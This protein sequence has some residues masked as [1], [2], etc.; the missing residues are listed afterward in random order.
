MLNPD[1]IQEFEINGYNLPKI[2]K[3]QCINQIKQLIQT[4][5]LDFDFIIANTK[6]T[7]NQMNILQQKSQISLILDPQNHYNISCPVFDFKK[8][9][10]ILPNKNRNKLNEIKSKVETLLNSSHIDPPQTIKK[11]WWTEDEDQQLQDLVSQYGAKNWKKIASFF[12]DRTDVQCLHRWQKV[13]NPDLVKGPW[14]QEEDELLVTLVVGYGPKN[15]SQIAKHL[16]GRI[17]K[18]CRERFHNHLD[19][20]IN[21]ERWTDEEDQTIIEA[22]KKLG[23]RWSLIA[24]LLKGR[25]D[26]SIK[27]HWNSTLKRRLKMQNRWEDLQVLQNQD[28]TQI[29]GIPRRH[30]Q[31]K[32]IYQKTPVKMIKPDPVS[33]QLNF[34]TPQQSPTKLEQFSKSLFIVFPN[35]NIKL[36][37]LSSVTLIKQ[38]GELVNFD[39]DFNKQY[40][41]E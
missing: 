30:M 41:Y 14:T 9:Q 2:D 21:K 40:S 4:H 10:E 16:P 36:M 20:K 27:N 19:P 23:N 18:Q 29:K 7:T 22:H 1:L 5:P 37:N 26:N 3:V 25:T 24:G 8:L 31:R 13:L 35:Y 17:G 34:L 33:R 6:L 39:L 38:L 32:I 28:D 15:W 11:R 12:Q